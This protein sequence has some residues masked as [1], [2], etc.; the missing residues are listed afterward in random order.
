MEDSYGDAYGGP[1]A[2]I[3]FWFPMILAVFHLVA[4]PARQAHRGSAV[5]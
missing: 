3:R 4:A 1:P 2:L 5:K